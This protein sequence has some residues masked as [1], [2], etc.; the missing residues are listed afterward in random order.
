MVTF[1]TVM[2]LEAVTIVVGVTQLPNPYAPN[3]KPRHK[4]V[5]NEIS[6][7]ERQAKF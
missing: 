4:L 5:I 7:Y 2:K 3:T 6:L 1:L